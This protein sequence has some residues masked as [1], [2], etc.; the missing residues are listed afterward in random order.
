MI[1]VLAV[2]IACG[3]VGCQDAKPTGP[4]PREKAQDDKI[5]EL[6]KRITALEQKPV[7][8]HY[9]LRNQGSR[10]FRFDPD[11]GNSCI[12]LAS[13]TDWKNPDTVRQGCHY[14][15]FMD[16]PY[17]TGE[18]YAQRYQVAECLFVSKCK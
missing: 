6:A 11:T 10:S 4:S 18:T 16:R 17:D 15:D 1:R 9:E 12:S 14:Q 8:H 5:Q 3:L 2:I 13:P 7:Q